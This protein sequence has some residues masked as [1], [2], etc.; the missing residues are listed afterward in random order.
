MELVEALLLPPG[1]GL[2]QEEIAGAEVA[3]RVGGRTQVVE[4]AVVAEA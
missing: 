3:C 2:V 1:G 4:P